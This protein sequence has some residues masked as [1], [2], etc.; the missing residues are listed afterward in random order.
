MKPIISLFLIVFLNMSCSNKI[1]N[2]TQE[3]SSSISISPYHKISETFS[4]NVLEPEIT[5]LE[6]A[7]GSL[8]LDVWF[9]AKR[10]GE[11]PWIVLPDKLNPVLLNIHGG[12]WTL[13]DKIGDTYNIMHYISR[14][15]SVVNINYRYVTEA[16]LPVPIADCRQALNWIYENTHT[17][18]LDTNNIVVSGDSSGGHYALMTGL[19]EH[20]NDINIPGK[21]VKRKLRVKAIIN[22][23]GMNDLGK[24]EQWNGKQLD[25]MDE[26]F[27]QVMVGD[28]ERAQEILDISSPKNY[29]TENSPP[30]ISI[31][32]D[33]D[34]I[35]PISQS[36]DLHKMLDSLQVTHKLVTV[37]GKKHLNFSA[38]ELENIYTEIFNFLESNTP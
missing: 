21:E 34:P 9:P 23:F 22:W 18:K 36:L 1:E 7:S 19:M 10:L 12:K 25:W 32:G 15:W 37:K 31:H 27:L 4:Q 16:P 35:V 38:E 13:G 8:K 6:T 2:N 26:D 14:G 17:Y 11:P 24:V 29:L 20:D 28:L 3:A 33:A 30:I 5:Y